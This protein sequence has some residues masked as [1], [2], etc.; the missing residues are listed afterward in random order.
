MVMLRGAR[1]FQDTTSVEL[2][3][4]KALL[5]AMT[6]A[7]EL[8]LTHVIFESDCAN[9]IGKLLRGTKVVCPLGNVIAWF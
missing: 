1:S 2:A 3:E 6:M 5:W 4:E 9:L 8:E 7:K